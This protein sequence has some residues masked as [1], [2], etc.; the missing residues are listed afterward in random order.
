MPQRH[1]AVRRQFLKL[2]CGSAIIVSSAAASV[3]PV[4]ASQADT[5]TIRDSK[6]TIEFDAN[7]RTRISAYGKPITQFDDSETLSLKGAEDYP[8]FLLVSLE[9]GAPAIDGVRGKAYTVRGVSSLGLEKVVNVTFDEAR[10]GLAMISTSYTSNAPVPIEVEGWRN[11]AHTLMAND[12]GFWSFSGASYADRRDWVQPMPTGFAQRN[13]MG[14]NASDYGGGTPVADVW[15]WDVGMAVGHVEKNPKMVALPIARTQD[16][17][18]IAIEGDQLVILAPGDTLTTHDCFLNV[19]KGDYFTALTTYREVMAERG[20]AAPKAPEGSYESVWCAWGYERNFTTKQ[21]LDTLPKV[22]DVGLKWAVLDDGWQTNEGDWQLDRTKFPQGDEDMR[23]FVRDIKAAGLRPR[24]WIAPLAVDP[25]SDLLHQNTDMLLLDQW[26]AVHDVTWWNSFTLCPA[27]QPTIDNAVALVKKIIGDWGFEGLKIDG[28]HLNGVAPCHNKAHN[29]ARPE[30]SYEKLQDFWQA[31]YDAAMEINPE[32]V[33]E[34]CPCGTSFAFHNVP[35]MNQT[36]S[37]DP[38]SS[39]QVRLKGKTFKALMGPSAAYAGDHVELS[40]DR[41]DFA[42]SVGIGAVV[43]TKFTWPYDTDNPIDKLPEGGFVLTDEKEKVWRRW[44]DIYNEK[45][46]PKGEYLGHLYDIGFDAPE[47]HAIRKGGKMYF[48]FYA[49]DFSG[50][51]ELRGLA[52]G[53]YTLKNLFTGQRLGRASR[54][55]TTLPV[56]FKQYLLLEATPVRGVPA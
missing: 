1:S 45:M 30:E 17:A 8:S 12:N 52:E 24:L 46:L 38:L 35:Y 51:V 53:T 10:P 48:S 34:L 49:E 6:M 15:R 23:A 28:Q 41:N 44:I 3:R 43:S 47:A 4:F 25:G 21:V 11:A 13:Y 29:H 56:E 19:H 9:E 22:K 37:S 16:G 40:D 14:M 2:M 32:A 20:L 42:T 50:E 26:G 33:I 55:S 27:Y 7:M 54:A 39:W 31:V 36:P 18:S 5:V